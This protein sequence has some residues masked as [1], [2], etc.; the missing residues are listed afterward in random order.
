MME[1]LIMGLLTGWCYRQQR[2]INRLNGIANREVKVVT[3]DD[4]RRHGT[5][6]TEFLIDSHIQKYHK[7]GR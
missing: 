1:W 5:D 3:E 4:I 2:E 7:G 6:V